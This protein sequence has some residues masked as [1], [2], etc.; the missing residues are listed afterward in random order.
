MVKI[1]RLAHG[2]I[3]AFECK[4]LYEKD[5]IEFVKLAKEVGKLINYMINNP[6]KFGVDTE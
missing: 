4:C 5:Y 3:C 2:S 1:Q 6:S